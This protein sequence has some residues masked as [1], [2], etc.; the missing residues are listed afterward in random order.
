[1]GTEIDPPNSTQHLLVTILRKPVDSPTTEQKILT[2]PLFRFAQTHN[3]F[4]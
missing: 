3:R 1:M 4:G 2:P